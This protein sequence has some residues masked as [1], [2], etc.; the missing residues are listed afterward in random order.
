MVS[1]D[2][3]ARGMDIEGVDYVVLYTAPKSV[4]NY[5]HRVGRTGRAGRPGTAVT[6]LLDGQVCF[7]Q[8]KLVFFFSFT[9]ICCFDSFMSV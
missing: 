5:I 9:H 7:P 1:S 2:A 4:K 3:L 6:F 8:M